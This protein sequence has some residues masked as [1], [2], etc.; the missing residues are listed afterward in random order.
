MKNLSNII[1]TVSC[2]FLIVFVATLFSSCNKGKIDS[3]SKYNQNPDEATFP[4][5]TRGTDIDAL[6]LEDKNFKNM[7]RVNSELM[8]LFVES[9]VSPND[10]D[11]ENIQVLCQQ[12]MISENTFRQFS[13]EMEEAIRRL[14]ADY[15][16][17]DETG[18]CP[19]CS[20]SEDG[21]IQYLRDLIAMFRETKINYN[22]EQYYFGETQAPGGEF[23]PCE[24]PVLAM[25]CITGCVAST[26]GVIPLMMMCSYVCI[27]SFCPNNPLCVNLMDTNSSVYQ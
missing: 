21:Q 8:G 7:L 24:R 10:F 11:F 9:N 17:I 23:G 1:K 5:E 22:L 4:P 20:M 15:R 26:S 18:D 19:L 14:I 16:F 3:N 12:L 2:L 13:N 25:L 6:I 27:C